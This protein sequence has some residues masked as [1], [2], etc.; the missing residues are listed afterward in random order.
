LKDGRAA[1]IFFV[2]ALVMSL[3]LARAHPFGDAGLYASTSAQMPIGENT[4]VPPEVRAILIAKCADCH[5]METRLPVYD[6]V[7]GRLAP[8]SWLMERDIVKGR[9]AMDLDQWSS[10]SAEQQQIFAAKMVQETKT[11]AMPLLQ[12]R[13]VHRN[14]RITDADVRTLAQWAHGIA[15]IEQQTVPE[16]APVA[17]AAVVRSASVA[18]QAAS[19]GEEH[20]LSPATAVDAVNQPP[21]EGDAVRGKDVFERRCTGCHAMD[22]DREGPRLQGVYGRSS[23]A[24]AGFEYS[25]ALKQA[26][27]VWDDAT[28]EQWLADP[29]TL[30]P[31][32][33][34][35][36]HVA[37]P[38][39]RQDLIE[40][41]K[42]S[43]VK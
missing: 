36:F 21:G 31:E 41:L 13:M 22:A 10:Y 28:L 9:K 30:V 43:A 17:K 26:H 5:S 27:I 19:A 11:H 42:L 14:A 38:Q 24:V 33:N 2:V 35:D 29:D 18:T 12:Y 1:S 16:P 4:T 34:M 6:Q 40:F 39:E 3:L 15:D 37:K 25:T 23:G 32:N 8:A 7:A 20:V